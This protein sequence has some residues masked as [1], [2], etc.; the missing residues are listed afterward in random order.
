MENKE[1][2]EVAEKLYPIPFPDKFSNM[3]QEA[4]KE[5]EAF[6]SGAKWQKEQDNN[7][8]TEEELEKI[9]KELFFTMANCDKNIIHKE[10]DFEK[11][12]EKFKKK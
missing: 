12:F 4:Y 6:I 2:K 8:F 7:K 11:W 9:S 3:N 1:L 10:F 5:R